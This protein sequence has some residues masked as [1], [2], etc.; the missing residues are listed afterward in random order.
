[1]PV[2]IAYIDILPSG[3]LLPNYEIILDFYKTDIANQKY[4]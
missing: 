1:M 2:H 4:I 3:S